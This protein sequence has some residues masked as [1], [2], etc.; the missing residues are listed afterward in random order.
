MRGKLKH[1]YFQKTAKDKEKMDGLAT[2]V[3]SP[4]DISTTKSSSLKSADEMVSRSRMGKIFA[5]LEDD[6]DLVKVLQ[7]YEAKK[8][9]EEAKTVRYCVQPLLHCLPTVIPSFALK[10]MGNM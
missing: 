1:V 9:R 5:K 10:F 8:T 7:K 4:T 6:V 3:S 2:A